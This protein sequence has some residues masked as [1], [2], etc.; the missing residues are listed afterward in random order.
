LKMIP[1]TKLTSDE[2]LELM[3]KDFYAY[4]YHGGPDRLSDHLEI[5]CD[6]IPIEEREAKWIK[7]RRQK[8][9]LVAG[10]FE[11]LRPK[12][13]EV[14]ND[15]NLGAIVKKADKPAPVYRRITGPDL[16]IV[17]NNA[18]GERK[19]I[20][21]FIQDNLARKLEPEDEPKEELRKPAAEPREKPSEEAS[22]N[23]LAN[24]TLPGVA[25]EVQDY[26]LRA[27][28]QPSPIMSLAVGLMVPTTLVCGYVSGPSGPKGCAL[29]QSLVVVAPTT[30]GK[31]WAIDCTKE[32]ICQ[33]GEGAQSLLGPNRFKSGTAVVRWVSE[34]RVSLC[35]QDEFGRLLAKFSDPKSN[36]CEVDIN[37][38]MREFW[39]IGPGGIY[40]S[41][42]GASKLDDSVAIVDPRLN[43]LGFGVHQEFYDAC[44]VEDISNGFLNR[45]A[46]LDERN[47]LYPNTDLEP[48][49]L[50]YDL[51]LNLG[52][53][54]GIKTP[55]KLDWTPAA[56]EIYDAEV[57]RVHTDPD[58]RKRK[59][60]GRTPERIVRAASTFAASRFAT[61]IERSDMEIAQAIMRQS[62][63][64]FTFG[65]DEAQKKR[66]LDHAGLKLEII[67]RLKVDFRNPE[68]GKYEASVFEIKRSF[69]HN[70]KHKKAVP[71]AIQDLIDSGTLKPA[72]IKTGGKHK[73]VCRLVEE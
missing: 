39:A 67:R 8:L 2:L 48:I 4:L 22:P 53:L 1:R 70:S 42:H 14:A 71:D 10:R 32:C 55:R 35:I 40:N 9:D 34:H 66:T 37:D 56:K 26:F 57:K 49:P 21:K 38:R 59:L 73:E 16:R 3:A 7:T 44:E 51:K 43:I 29:H 33:A 28:M 13:E 50:P 25:G 64:T 17:S 65:I 15:P 36:P 6:D 45:L 62:D 69:R 11:A 68:T 12:I 31:Q 52:K 60:W 61:K 18:G 19:A 27:A 41:P 58:E 46:V 54:Y 23:S 20:Q 24:L 63:A 5:D 72:I 47:T 30:S